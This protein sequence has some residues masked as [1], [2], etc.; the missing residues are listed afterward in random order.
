[1][2][3]LVGGVKVNARVKAAATEEGAGAVMDEDDLGPSGSLRVTWTW[4]WS[5]IT[6]HSPLGSLWHPGI[7]LLCSPVTCRPS[8]VNRTPLDL[9]ELQSSQEDRLRI[10]D[11]SGAG[12]CPA[13]P[14][15]QGPGG[16]CRDLVT[17]GAGEACPAGTKG[18]EAWGR[19]G[20]L[21][22]VDWPRK[23]LEM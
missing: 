11:E 16:S 14:G 15:E 9:K 17:C 3:V 1:M 13:S 8:G 22:G 20:H 18:D 2:C 12:S 21:A 6:C 5:H 10:T 7:P 19:A 23:G 4:G